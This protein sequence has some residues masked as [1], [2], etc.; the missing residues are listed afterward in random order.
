M[1]FCFTEALLTYRTWP[2]RKPRAK[3]LHLAWQSV[4]IILLR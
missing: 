3:A 4:G 2:L 1:V